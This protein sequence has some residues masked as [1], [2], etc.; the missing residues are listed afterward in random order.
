MTIQQFYNELAWLTLVLR[1]TLLATTKL[2]GIMGFTLRID[3]QPR[4]SITDLDMAWLE[5]NIY[6]I[7]SEFA[8]L[9]I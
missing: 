4:Y 1:R 5:L 9:Y 7:F 8:Q 2:G 6:A 3:T